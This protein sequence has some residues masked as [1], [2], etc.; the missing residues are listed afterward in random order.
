MSEFAQEVILITGAASGIGRELSRQLLQ[1]GARIAAVDRQ[2]EALKALERE[3][4]PPN[5]AWAV[6]DVTDRAALNQAVQDLEQR[7]GP[8]DRLIVCA[9]IGQATPAEAFPGEVFEAVVRVNLI[10]AANSIQAVLPGMIRR[11]RGHLVA[12]SSLASFRGIP[13]LSGYSASKA[14]V[15]ALM[16]SLCVELK[17][18]GI[19]VSTICPGWIRTPMT[20]PIANFLPRLL[21]VEEAARRILTAVRRRKRFTAFPPRDS[22]TLRLL[23]MLPPSAGDWFFGRIKLPKVESP[24]SV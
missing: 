19:H 1:E 14:G 21:T 9:G 6:A 4:K 11:R 15:N 3:W 23:R 5:L 12:L 8:V 13:L 7:L 24:A 16:D 17:P 18:H 10:G 20:A 22:F 2:A